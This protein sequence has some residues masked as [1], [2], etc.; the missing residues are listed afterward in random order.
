MQIKLLPD[1]EPSESLSSDE[2]YTCDGTLM[3]RV[4]EFYGGSIP[5]DVA[6][7]EFANSNFVR[8]DHYYTKDDNGLSMPWANRNWCN[9]PYSRGQMIKWVRKIIDC[10]QN[11]QE[12][13]LLCNG[14]NSTAWWQLADRY[15]SAVLMLSYRLAF[16][17]PDR[18]KIISGNMQ[19][20]HLFYFGERLL[21][22]EMH[23]GINSPNPLGS[24]H[25][26]INLINPV[27]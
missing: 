20:Q 18:A 26:P 5:L 23:F 14:D 19:P 12:T 13:L 9:P 10:A 27:I 4:K 25:V 3:A 17:N 1:S 24:V 7:C 15:A 8:A 2:R 16:Y 22:F 6:S 11:G 21:E